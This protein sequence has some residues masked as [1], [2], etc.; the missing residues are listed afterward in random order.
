MSNVIE[1]PR[2]RSGS[3]EIRSQVALEI[4]LNLYALVGAAVLIRSVLLSLDVSDRVWI[5]RTVYGLTD[6]LVLPLKILPGADRVVV[7]A[8]TLA[9]A[10]VLAGVVLM[11]LGLYWLGA[12]RLRP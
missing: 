11:P 12:R 5:G 9:D 10:T 4:V 7:G 8:L 1:P 2:L 3:Q 6:L